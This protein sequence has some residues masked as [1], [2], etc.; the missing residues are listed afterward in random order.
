MKKEER[1]SEAEFLRRKPV[2]LVLL[3][4]DLRLEQEIGKQ[5]GFGREAEIQ[6][7]DAAD[8]TLV[9]VR[10]ERL[11]RRRGLELVRNLHGGGCPRHAV[12]RGRHAP[13]LT[14]DQSRSLIPAH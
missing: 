14:V 9:E 4:H 5:R 13:I 8:A 6:R 12:A 2:A 7:G 3:V 1:T 10:S 11:R